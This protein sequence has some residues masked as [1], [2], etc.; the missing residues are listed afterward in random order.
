MKQPLKHTTFVNVPEDFL[1]ELFEY[2]CYSMEEN[3]RA[4]ISSN[5]T[6]LFCERFNS[7]CQ[8]AEIEEDGNFMLTAQILM[9]TLSIA[10]FLLNSSVIIYFKMFKHKKQLSADIL[11]SFSCADAIFAFIFALSLAIQ[12]AAT[13]TEKKTLKYFELVTDQIV[14]FSI[15]ASVFHVLAITIERYC[16]VIIPYKYAHYVKTNGRKRCIPIIW[17]LTLS[18]QG[19]MAIVEHVG[20]SHKKHKQE[21]IVEKTWAIIVLVCGFTCFVVYSFIFIFLVRAWNITSKLKS[22]CRGRKERA[23]VITA[24]SMALGFLIFTFPLAVSMFRESS[25]SVAVA[26]RCLFITNAIFNP[27]VY[28]WKGEWTKRY[29]QNRKACKASHDTIRSKKNSESLLGAANTNV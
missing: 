26:V 25:Y 11:F 8:D 27:V 16:A 22:R 29:S 5:E 17:I 15:Y 9:L 2:C 1:Q 18:L 24:V 23:A 20:Q 28:F 19:I 6:S 14:Q 4:N 12:L 3:L 7:I 10:A 21:I 13:R